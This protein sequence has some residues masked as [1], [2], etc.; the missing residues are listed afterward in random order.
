MAIPVYS[1]RFWGSRKATSGPS[2][3]VP[4]GF[5]AVARDLWVA[6]GSINAGELFDF[7]GSSGQTLWN[8]EFSTAQFQF[9]FWQGHQV[10]FEGETFGMFFSSAAGFDVTC[11]GYLLTNS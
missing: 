4:S 3:T 5:T 7:T 10:F 9:Y 1:T 2:F 11:S 8:G 6:G